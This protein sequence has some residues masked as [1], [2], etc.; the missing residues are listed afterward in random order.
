MTKATSQQPDVKTR[1]PDCVF[2]A[3]RDGPAVVMRNELTFAVRDTTPVTF[4]HTLV[5]PYRHAATYFDLT[6]PELAA[7]NELLRHLRSEIIKTDPLVKG[8][9]VGANVGLVSGQ[10]IFHCHVHLIPRR[11][12]DIPDP[13]GGVRA[14][15]PDKMRY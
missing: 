14:V 13:L 12:G 5:L 11:D 10:T 9:N 8:F 7:A 2:C 1:A 3:L 15:I 4:L 6:D